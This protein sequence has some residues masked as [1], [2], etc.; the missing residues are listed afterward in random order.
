MQIEDLQLICA[1]LPGT[2]EDI[3]WEDHLCFN[4]GD[5][6]YLITSPDRFPHSASF[7]A[8]DDDFSLLIEQEGIQPAP[9]LARYKWVQVDDIRRLSRSE[10]ISYIKS[11]YQLVLSKLPRKIQQKI[12]E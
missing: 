5:K 3:K 9:Y 1:K 11:S 8:T 7:K 10:W 12:S 6:M 4:V 2:T